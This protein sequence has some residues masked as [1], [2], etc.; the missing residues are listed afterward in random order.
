[1]HEAQSPVPVRH[2]TIATRLPPLVERETLVPVCMYCR[3]RH[4]AHGEWRPLTVEE[5][6]QPMVFTH[7]VCPACLRVRFGLI[8]P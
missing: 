6:D 2:Q 3:Q 5:L 8:T 1:M 4:T 7:G